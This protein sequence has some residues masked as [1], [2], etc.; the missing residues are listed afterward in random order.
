MILRPT[1]SYQIQV[2]DEI[3]Q[4]VAGRVSSLW[5]IGQS[6][7]LQLSSYQ[8]TT[9]DQVSAAQRLQD[10]IDKTP[11][12]WRRVFERLCRDQAADQAVAERFDGES[13]W[14]HC[15][16]VWPHLTV[17]VTLSGAVKEVQNP[18]SWARA[19]LSSLSISLQ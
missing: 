11:S 13:L 19:A 7:L 18:S 4:D 17:Y 16:L 1:S 5:M 12:D 6:L 2:P 9:G 8:R 15:Y 10:R 14:L 3:R